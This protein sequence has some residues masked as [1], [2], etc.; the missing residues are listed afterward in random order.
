MNAR[1]ERFLNRTQMLLRGLYSSGLCVMYHDASLAVRL[2]ENAP[3]SWPQ[4]EAILNEG[5][6]AI[7]D[8]TT[9]EQVIAAKRRVQETGVPAQI[10]AAVRSPGREPTWFELDIEP[11]FAPE[12]ATEPARRDVCGLFISVS[13]ITQLKRREEALRALLYEVS[14]R[15]R[16]LLA[17]LQSILGHTA[18]H[19]DSIAEFERK[20]RGRIAS[21]AHSQDLITTSNWQ[22]VR[23]RRLAE[24]QF[25]AYLR[26][27]L[28]RPLIHGADPVLSPNST[29]HIG[30][31]LHELA[32]NSANFGALAASSGSIVI[33][34]ELL[35]EAHCMSW[36]EELAQPRQVAP[37]RGFGQAVLEQVVTR[38]VN[39][40]A[41]Y[42]ILPERIT[43]RIEWPEP[44]PGLA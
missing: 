29:L 36:H 5:D 7:F 30:L 32:A 41:E 24:S 19:S 11:D 28:P 42:R 8:R 20:F 14:H 13:D 2:V 21:L 35:P 31:A 18:R 38:A 10:E 43:Y 22:G 4:P 23:F 44:A 3:D 39:G 12:G 17:I 26:P 16:N 9:A 25:T 15:S 1:D 27:G 34:S 6:R 37:S 40:H 33:E